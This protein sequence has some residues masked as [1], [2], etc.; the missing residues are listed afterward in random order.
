MKC[1]W[2]LFLRAA[3]LKPKGEG[4]HQHVKNS[5]SE[6][7][8]RNWKWGYCLIFLVSFHHTWHLWFIINLHYNKPKSLCLIQTT[9]IHMFT[10]TSHSAT[11]TWCYAVCLQPQNCFPGTRGPAS[12]PTSPLFDFFAFP[13][14]VV[15]RQQAS[16][17]AESKRTAEEQMWPLHSGQNTGGEQLFQTRNDAV[18]SYINILFLFVSPSLSHFLFLDH[19]GTKN[20]HTE[21]MYSHNMQA[22]WY[23]FFPIFHFVHFNFTEFWIQF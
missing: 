23:Q 6:F 1:L 7:T 13:F 17:R 2:F 14:M 5:N 19:F 15:F 22:L 11:N 20:M 12:V 9:L 10:F 18:W 3:C 16:D 21:N 4:H 8:G